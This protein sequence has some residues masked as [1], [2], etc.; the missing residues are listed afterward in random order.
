M[1]EDKDEKRGD[2]GAEMITVEVN[3]PDLGPEPVSLTLRR[4]QWEPQEVAYHYL[5]HLNPDGEGLPGVPTADLTVAQVKE[6]PKHIQKSLAHEV[7]YVTPEDL[8]EMNE[9]AE[10]KRKADEAAAEEA[11]KPRAVTTEKAPAEGAGGK[12]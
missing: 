3:H 8:A 11:K 4:D 6:F 12:K 5:I 9:E 2:P 7:Y 10:R 1:A